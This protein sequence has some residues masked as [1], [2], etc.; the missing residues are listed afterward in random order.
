M[1][2]D[3]ATDLRSLGNVL[4][5]PRD[6]P[7]AAGAEADRPAANM[8]RPM[9]FYFSTDTGVLWYSTGSA[10]TAASNAFG[11][12]VYA[13]LTSGESH[14]TSTSYGDPNVSGPAGPSLSSLPDGNYVL[15]FGGSGTMDAG[16]NG[17]YMGISVNGGGITD[18]NACETQ[19]VGTHTSLGR[20]TTATLSSGS[21]TLAAKYRS[22]S[23]NDCDFRY[24]YLVAIKYS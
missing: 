17:A 10:W 6:L 8:I 2:A 21:N 5:D 23:G 15:F 1:T 3:P 9:A 11:P 7:I 22:A 18:D 13:A 16:G 14:F 24:R 20:A 4:F 12:K 19:L